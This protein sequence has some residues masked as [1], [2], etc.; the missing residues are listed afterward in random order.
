LQFTALHVIAA[1]APVTLIKGLA[2]QVKLLDV[3][4]WYPG[5][6]GAS[7][8]DAIQVGTRIDTRPLRDVVADFELTKDLQREVL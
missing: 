8:N 1:Q 3:R 5:I 2:R 7:V 4:L 6:T